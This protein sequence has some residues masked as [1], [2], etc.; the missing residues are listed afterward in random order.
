M[1]LWC[2]EIDGNAGYAS[3]RCVGKLVAECVKH[4]GHA[5]LPPQ[6]QSTKALTAS[7]TVFIHDFS[8]SRKHTPLKLKTCL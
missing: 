8:A 7:A 4:F 1:E 6:M 5:T 3:S 2:R